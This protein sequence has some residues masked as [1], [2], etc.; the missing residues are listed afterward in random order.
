[1]DPYGHHQPPNQGRN[2][3]T[4]AAQGGGGGARSLTSAE[5]MREYQAF[6]AAVRAEIDR[7]V[8]SGYRR[9]EAV[10][11]LL[12]R[13]KSLSSGADGVPAIP[14]EREVR[15]MICPFFL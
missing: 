8:R 3:A 14:T 15:T 9:E 7:M 1:M 13:I 10:E 11:T 6:M 5:H 2:V 4:G 12:R